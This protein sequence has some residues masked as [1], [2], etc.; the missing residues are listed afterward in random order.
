MK[1]SALHLFLFYINYFFYLIFYKTEV[2]LKKN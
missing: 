2:K 1:K